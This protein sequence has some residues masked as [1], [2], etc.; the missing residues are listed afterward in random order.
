MSALQTARHARYRITFDHLAQA[1][2]ILDERMGDARCCLPDETGTL[3]PLRFRTGRAARE[4]LRLC[5]E[6]N[7]A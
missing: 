1:H 5:Q 7:K 3:R 6:G 2:F 4:W